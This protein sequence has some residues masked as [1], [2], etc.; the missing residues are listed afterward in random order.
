MNRR[1]LTKLA[2]GA[3]IA[4]AVL[5]LAAPPAQA[6]IGFRLKIGSSLLRSSGGHGG[7]AYHRYR[8]HGLY[9]APVYRSHR[10]CDRTYGRGTGRRVTASSPHVQRYVTIHQ[11]P[12][13]YRLGNVV[14]VVVYR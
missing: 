2:V 7:R 14:V 13:V 6:G 1:K 9:R 12:S 5:L 3:A 10:G 11:R 8:S 4:V